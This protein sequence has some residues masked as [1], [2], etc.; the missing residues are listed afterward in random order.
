MRRLPPRFQRTDTL[1][2]YTTLFRTIACVTERPEGSPGDAVDVAKALR[3][4]AKTN[5]SLIVKGGVLGT[6]P[7]SA[8]EAKALA[9][10]EPRDVLLAKLAGEIGRAH[11]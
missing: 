6:K 7:L 5:P 11:V 8:D 10:V 3:D 9:D 4:F 2:P 1:F